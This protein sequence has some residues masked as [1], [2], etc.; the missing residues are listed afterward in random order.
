M[1]LQSVCVVSSN[2]TSIL[3]GDLA[4]KQIEEPFVSDADDGEE[5]A[6]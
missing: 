5:W 4:I 1:L 2:S 6:I 3:C